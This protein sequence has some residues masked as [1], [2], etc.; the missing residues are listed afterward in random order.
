MEKCHR[1][2]KI[3]FPE[4]EIYIGQTKKSLNERWCDGYYGCNKIYEAILKYGKHNPNIKK[5][6]ITDQ[7]YQHDAD[8]IERYYIQYYNSIPNTIVLNEQNGGVTGFKLSKKAKEKISKS[9]KEYYKNHPEKAEKHS[10]YMKQFY[11]DHPEEKEKMRKIGQEVHKKY[12]ELRKAS[13][14]KII[15]YT[16]NMQYVSSYNSLKEAA[17]TTGI[18]E[19]SISGCLRNKTYTAGNYRWYYDNDKTYP[20]IQYRDH[21]NEPV[22]VIQKDK[23]TKRIIQTYNSISEASKNTGVPRSNI[24]KCLKQD[25]NRYKSAGGFIWEKV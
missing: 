15:Q 24:A 23:E 22:Q 20:L 6:F 25:G 21:D 19:I 4:G 17:E 13:S 16:Y 1:V 10:K 11:E 12:P 18:N 3:T 7:L 8:E 5:E 9:E 14:K 2:Y